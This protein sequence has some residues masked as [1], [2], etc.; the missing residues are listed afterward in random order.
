M[1]IELVMLS[2]EFDKVML[3]MEYYSVL[4]IWALKLQRYMKE[5]ITINWKKLIW[6]GYIM[7]DSIDTPF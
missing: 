6:E 1:F 5:T 4:K 7:Y 2:M 3:P